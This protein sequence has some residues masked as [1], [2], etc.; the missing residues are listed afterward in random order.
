LGWPWLILGITK[1]A[2]LKVVHFQS[3]P[4][5]SG[6]ILLIMSYRAEINFG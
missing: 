3:W 1:Y 6:W 2:T 5:L 4:N